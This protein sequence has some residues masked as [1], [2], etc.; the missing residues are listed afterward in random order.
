MENMVN[1]REKLNVFKGK[2]VFLTGHTGF[3]GSWMAATLKELGAIVKGYSLKCETQYS[4]FELLSLDI[5]SEIGDIRNLDQLKKSVKDFKPDV[6][7]HLAAQPLVRYSYENPI[8]TYSTNVM[9]TLNV[10]EA[11]RSTDSVKAIVNVTTDKCYKN[12]EWEWGYREIDELG[13]YDPYSS[14]KACSELLTDSYRN[15]YFNLDKFGSNHHCLIASARAG[16]VI[17]G[18]DWSEDRIIPDI[19]RSKVNNKILHIRNPDSTRPWQHVIEPVMGYLFL[20]S[21]L[22]N[23]EKKFAGA[24]NFGPDS[25]QIHKVKEIVEIGN[26][27]FDNS[28]NIEFGKIKDTPHEAN[29]LMLDSSKANKHLDWFGKFDFITTTSMTFDWYNEFYKKQ[30]LITKNQINFY[31]DK[32]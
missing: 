28:L 11:A 14:S 23:G 4:H 6:I 8:E 20:G 30:K 31:L 7:F 12:N 10:F 25:T 3:K 1:Q 2:R 18:G 26:R 22:L 19:I 17:G 9:G 15:S 21:H 27:V 5:E 29:L 32:L 13:G 24:W 16:N